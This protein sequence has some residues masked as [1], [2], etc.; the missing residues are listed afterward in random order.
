MNNCDFVKSYYNN[1]IKSKNN[2]NL[3]VEYGALY[4]YGHHFPIAYLRDKS[5]V[6]NHKKYS[7]TSSKH[8]TLARNCAPRNLV[9]VFL[10]TELFQTFIAINKAGLNYD[11]NTTI[12]FCDDFRIFY[13][14]IKEHEKKATAK[15][16]YWKEIL[17]GLLFFMREEGFEHKVFGFEDVLADQ[18]LNSLT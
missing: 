9:E 3:L 1:P 14:E 12:R 16:E 2:G 6:F 7:I 15:K 13:N 8:Q 4:S 18:I 11:H 10:P 17:Q 5:I